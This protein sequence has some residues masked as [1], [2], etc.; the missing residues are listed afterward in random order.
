[1]TS[2]GGNCHER[3]DS[4][5]QEEIEHARSR[6][7]RRRSHR[8]I[9]N[10]RQ[11]ANGPPGHDRR[12]RSRRTNRIQDQRSLHHLSDHAVVAD[13]RACRSVGNPGQGESLGRR[14]RCRADAKRRRCRGV[15]ARLAANRGADDDVHCV[16]GPAPDDP[17]HVQDRGRADVDRFSHRVA[18]DRGSGAVDIRRPSGRHGRAA[19]RLC[20]AL[21]GLC[22]GSPGLCG[23]QP[24]SDSRKPRAVP[25]FLRWLQNIARDQH[26][27][28]RR[29]RADRRDDRIGVHSRAPGPGV[30]SGARVHPRHGAKSGHVL[31]GPGDRQP[32]LCR[33]ARYRP[34]LHGSVRI[35]D[36]ATV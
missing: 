25:A 31:S 4:P 8:T 24:G 21:L 2:G 10:G 16:A 11:P 6:S 13:G 15:R 30:E 1:V 9:Q 12:Q 5:Q 17:E 29:G 34:G 36:R 27:R 33:D 20:D 23:N 19:D 7:R 32:L 18:I 35:A 28:A 14:A 3:I 22:A 26:D